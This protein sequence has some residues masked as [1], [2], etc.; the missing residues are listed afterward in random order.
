M[1]TRFTELIDRLHRAAR[2]EE[3]FGTLHGDRQAALKRR[4]RELAAVVH[5]DHNPESSAE[6]NEA[7]RALQ[8][9]YTNARLRL[10]EGTYGSRPYITAVTHLH[11]YTGYTPPLQGDLCELFPCSVG[12]DR[13]LLKVARSSRNNDLLQAEAETLGRLERTLAGQPIRAHFPRLIEPFRLRDTAGAIRHV[14]VL[15]AESDYV[16]LAD[17]LRAYPHGVDA[18]DAAWMFN[19]VLAALGVAHSLGI[20]HGAVVPAHV[21]IRLADHNAMLIDWCYSVAEGAPLKAVSPAYT[22]DYPPE[23]SARQPATSA[24]DVYMAARCMLRLLGGDPDSSSLPPGTPKPIAALLRA[25]LLP[26]PRRRSSD[27]WQIFEDF[28]EILAQRYGPRAFRPFAIPGM[29]PSTAR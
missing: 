2:P 12:S 20:V 10:D 29:T 23:V 15:G 1:D 25:C 24:T 28:Q 13:L 16:S 3:V 19:R 11:Q 27:A 6:A 5:P 9:W 7:F 17:V 8:S 4:Y 21:L 14:N 18:A 26:S 22:A